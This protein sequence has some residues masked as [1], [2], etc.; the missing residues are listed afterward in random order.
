MKGH[1]SRNQA[2]VC[3]SLTDWRPWEKHHWT[4]LRRCSH[5]RP[6]LSPS[7]VSRGIK[8]DHSVSS[9]QPKEWWTDGRMC[10]CPEVL[11]P[12]L[13]IEK[14]HRPHHGRCFA[15][16]PKP[17]TGTTHKGPTYM[18]WLTPVTKHRESQGRWATSRTLHSQQ[19]RA[20]IAAPQLHIIL[21]VLTSLYVL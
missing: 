5:L 18:Q 1:L 21:Y 13:H 4:S 3:L 8:W 20:R 19:V 16:P 15:S 2:W 9:L 6:L 7:Q 10:K 17:I 11:N 12:W 14:V